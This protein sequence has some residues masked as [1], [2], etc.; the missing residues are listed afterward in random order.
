[1]DRVVRRRI[2][3]PWRGLFLPRPCV[4]PFD[5]PASDRQAQGGPG[6]ASAVRLVACRGYPERGDVF[7]GV[8]GVR[9]DGH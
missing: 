1:M 2:V 3:V 8:W 5:D 7:A 6:V 4:G 9:R